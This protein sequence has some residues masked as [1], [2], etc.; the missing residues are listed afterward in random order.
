MSALAAFWRVFRDDSRI[1]TDS[2]AGLRKGTQFELTLSTLGRLSRPEQLAQVIV[3][4]G[5]D[6]VILT[7]VFFV[8]L[9]RTCS[10][11]GKTERVSQKPEA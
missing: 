10:N 3:E 1:A 7:P 5:K 11:A 9:S 8:L 2:A 4:T 6:A